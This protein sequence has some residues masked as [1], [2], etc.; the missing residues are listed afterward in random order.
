MWEP[1]PDY[2]LCK[3]LPPPS[4]RSYLEPLVTNVFD[5]AIQEEAGTPVKRP[6]GRPRKQELP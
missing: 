6:R 3:K 5:T 1:C 2:E 4:P